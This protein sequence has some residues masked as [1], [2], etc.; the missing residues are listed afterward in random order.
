MLYAVTLISQCL[1]Q[2]LLKLKKPDK[3]GKEQDILFVS[4]DFLF[5]S[6][7]YIEI[8]NK[9][10]IEAWGGGG[11]GGGGGCTLW[12]DIIT[13]VYEYNILFLF[14]LCTMESLYSGTLPSVLI[15][16]GVLISEV[17]LYYYKLKHRMGHF[18]LFLITGLSSF[19]R[20]ICTTI[21]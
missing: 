5:D 17:D 11:G 8:I 9:G 3:R 20:W 12:T 21:N 14:C 19:Q 18:K 2:L 16:R 13:F 6:E 1:H 10:F 7:N 15:N 4:T